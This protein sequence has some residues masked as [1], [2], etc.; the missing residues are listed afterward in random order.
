MVYQINL[1][2][3][4]L[5]LKKRLFIQVDE[6]DP[7][8]QQRDEVMAD[9][10]D[11]YLLSLGVDSSKK[12]LGPGYTD[13]ALTDEELERYSRQIIVPGMGKEGMYCLFL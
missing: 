5:H 9:S 12:F 6:M 2:S 11:G 8:G 13:R 10:D 7:T 4:S 1:T 3:P